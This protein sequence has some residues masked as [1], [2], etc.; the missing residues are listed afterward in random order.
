MLGTSQ[1]KERATDMATQSILRDFD[2]PLGAKE[3]ETVGAELQGMLVDLVDLVL[4]GKQAHWNVEEPHFSSL[5]NL[6][7]EF[8]DAWCELED[9]VAERA[10][11]IGLAPDGRPETLA[12]SSK[13]ESLSAGPLKHD[14]V[15]RAIADRL[16]HVI[17]RTRARMQGL[18]FLDPVTEDL[19][20][21]VAAT[22][23]KQL[24]MVRVQYE[25][26]EAP[27]PDLVTLGDGA[28]LLPLLEAFEAGCP[29]GVVEVSR[30]G[31]RVADVRLGMAEDILWVDF[32]TAMVDCRELWG[33]GNS[34]V[35]QRLADERARHRHARFIQLAA[36]RIG[37][38]AQEHGWDLV[39]LNGDAHLVEQL[40]NHPLLL[41]RTLEVETAAEVAERRSA[42]ENA[43][44]AAAG[45]ART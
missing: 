3:R 5:H 24:S 35:R 44:A 19:L 31:V 8:V 11:A 39:L 17:A 4:V 40:R 1:S 10:V 32:E 45:L 28:Q 34:A 43:E 14:E 23:K 30:A 27:L 15:V 12:E 25:H 9:D 18:A 38:L 21:Q 6:L 42:D 41:N 26:A 37:R 7:D 13:M 22:L 33:P 29:V 36:G 16:G 2:L 20:I